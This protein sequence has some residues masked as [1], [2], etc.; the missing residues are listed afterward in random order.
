MDWARGQRHCRLSGGVVL[1]ALLLTGLI[2]APAGSA[3]LFVRTRPRSA[4]R[5]AWP[6]SR[7]FV[8]A[9]VGTAVLALFAASIV[10]LIGVCEQHTLA[11]SAGVAFASLVWLPLTR[12]WSA[13]GHLCWAS[14]IFLFVVYLAYVLDWT[15]ASHLGVA[16]TVGGVLLWLFEL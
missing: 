3:F 4:S 13:R 14:S 9:L 11:D 8:L 7:R 15:F 12:R 2:A 16:G 5:G 6:A 1:G 10:R